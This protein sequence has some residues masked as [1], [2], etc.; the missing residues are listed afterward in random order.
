[1]KL[2]LNL[3]L[4]RAL[5]ATMFVVSVLSTSAFVGIIDTRCD[6]QCYLDFCCNTGT[7]LSG[8]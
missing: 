6:M 8:Q 3:S 4:R 5:L 2:H 7:S 1:M